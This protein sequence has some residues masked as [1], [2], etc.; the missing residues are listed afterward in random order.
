MKIVI[1]YIYENIGEDL[2]VKD[3][4]GII[5]ISPFHFS[6][7]FKS[8]T[9]SPPHQYIMQVRIERAKEML[10]AGTYALSDI[11]YTLGLSSQSHFN[12]FFKQYTGQTPQQFIGD[13]K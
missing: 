5:G 9:G 13:R 2:K 12:S 10:L 8:Y 3:M 11:A 4:A 7:L 6:R 1:D